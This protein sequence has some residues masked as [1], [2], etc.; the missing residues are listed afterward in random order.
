MN[1]ALSLSDHIRRTF[2][3]AFPV[4]LARAGLV[5]MIAIDTILVGRFSSHEL[6][7]FA[8]SSAPQIIMVAVS[9]GLMVGTVVLTAQ[10]DGAGR[11]EGMR[12]LLA[13]GHAAVGGASACYS[14]LDS[15]ARRSAAAR[16]SARVTI[17]PWAAAG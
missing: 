15:A 10:A 17:L 3:L 5:V 6:A 13:A 11:P 7:F 9:V 4:M 8:I 12:P 16:C 14:S 1:P 2:T